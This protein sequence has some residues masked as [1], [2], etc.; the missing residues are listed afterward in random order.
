MNASEILQQLEPLGTP[1]Y[2]R[3]LANHGIPEPMYGVRIGDFKSL[4]RHRQLWLPEPD[5]RALGRVRERPWPH[6][7]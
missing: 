1:G 2:R 4:D 6:G 5:H 3:I 7:T